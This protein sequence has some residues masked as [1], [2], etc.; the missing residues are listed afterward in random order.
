MLTIHFIHLRNG[1]AVQRILAGMYSMAD[2]Q[3]L[4]AKIYNI[5]YFIVN[6][7][8]ANQIGYALVARGKQYEDNRKQQDRSPY[9]K[10]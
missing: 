2:E 6:Q 7:P 9:L 1:N 4:M 3:I 5:W 8:G 10:G